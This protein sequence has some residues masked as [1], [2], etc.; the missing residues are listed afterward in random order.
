MSD[1]P[2]PQREEPPDRYSCLAG[3]LA[4]RGPFPP[5]TNAAAWTALVRLA[6]IEGVAPLLY[7]TLREHPGASVPAAVQEGL[8][9]LYTAATAQSLRHESVTRGLCRR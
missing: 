1:S 3:L 4:V 2:G 7:R 5:V 6:Q 9:A 8:A